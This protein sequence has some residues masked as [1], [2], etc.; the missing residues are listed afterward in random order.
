MAC[1]HPP[2][3]LINVLRSLELC[4]AYASNVCAIS[5]AARSPF[6]CFHSLR[7][8]VSKTQKPAARTS[9]QVDYLSATLSLK[10][11]LPFPADLITL[12]YLFESLSGCKEVDLSVRWV[13]L[14]SEHY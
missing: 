10:S 5:K 3:Q 14:N 4:D 8:N 12:L 1:L 7:R 9:T 13:S 6:Y 11:L 2:L